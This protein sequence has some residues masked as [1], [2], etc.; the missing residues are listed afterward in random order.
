MNTLTAATPG[1]FQFEG[2]RA[3]FDWHKVPIIGLVLSI[4]EFIGSSVVGFR[5]RDGIGRGGF[6]V[7]P[8]R[9]DPGRVER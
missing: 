1:R 8:G 6:R 5:L 9:L 4:L 7:K 3:N 2:P